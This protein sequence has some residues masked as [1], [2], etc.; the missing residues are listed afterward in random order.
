MSTS[1]G[2]ARNMSTKTTISAL[3]AVTRN[4]RTTASARPERE[5]GDHDR[6]R[7]LDGDQHALED[8]RAV[9]RDQVR[10]EEGLDEAFP[11]GHGVQRS[12]LGDEGARARLAW[13]AEDLLRRAFLDDQPVVHE[14][15]AVGGVAREAHLVA[16]HQHGHAA[17]LELAHHGE[18]R[19][20]QLRIE[21]RGRLVEQHHG[22]LE[23]ER[24]RD[25][26]ALLLAAGEL[27]RIGVGLRR[28]ARRARAPPCRAA[29][30]S[31]RGL[32]STLRS[33]SVTFPS[34]VMCG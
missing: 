24:A 11:G 29:S 20:D 4:A 1:G 22:R 19:A 9:L 34:A 23:R 30:A 28:Q 18:H 14:D 33:A 7:D 25:R 5:P 10:L 12:Q 15:D 13:R 32:S 6:E 27:G 26:D 16:D 2:S 17:G 21:R 8:R 31:A 3:T